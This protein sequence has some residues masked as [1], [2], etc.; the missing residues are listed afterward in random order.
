MKSMNIKENYKICTN[1]VMDTTDWSTNFDNNGVYNH[2]TN[3]YNNKVPNGTLMKKIQ[4]KFT[5]LQIK[6]EKREKKKT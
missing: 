6:Y 5:R 2:C 3:S 4:K 1:C